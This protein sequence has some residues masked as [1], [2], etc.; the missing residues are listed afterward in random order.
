MPITNVL[1]KILDRDSRFYSVKGQYVGSYQMEGGHDVK[2]TLRLSRT[3][4]TF[5]IVYSV[6]FHSA[7]NFATITQ[8]V[9]TA[10]QYCNTGFF[11][12]SQEA[13][14]VYLHYC[15]T[16]WIDRDPTRASLEELMALG[17]VELS[18]LMFNISQHRE[19]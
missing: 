8:E 15:Q 14:D 4:C 11:K 9:A 19:G 5:T 3:N 7:L 10:N 6:P 16:I 17:P 13:G 12:C 1:R 2:Y 18:S